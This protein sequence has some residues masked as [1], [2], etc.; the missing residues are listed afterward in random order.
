MAVDGAWRPCMKS[1]RDTSLSKLQDSTFPHTA[2][3]GD[4]GT[5]ICKSVASKSL[6]RF[7]NRTACT[8]VVGFSRYRWEKVAETGQ[9]FESRRPSCEQASGPA[10]SHTP[11][12]T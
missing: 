4:G 9:V 12:R 7:L 3:G 10:A 11:C 1:E 2:G 5:S 8:F 6:A